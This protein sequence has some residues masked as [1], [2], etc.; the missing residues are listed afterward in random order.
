MKEEKSKRGCTL[1]EITCVE[2]RYLFFNVLSQFVTTMLKVIQI[3]TLLCFL[4][5]AAFAANVKI[6]M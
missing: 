3:S 6:G 4:V 5:L 2:L 1:D